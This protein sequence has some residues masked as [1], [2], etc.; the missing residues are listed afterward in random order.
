MEA[1]LGF[2]VG[3]FLGTKAGREGLQELRESW[4]VVSASDEF[5]GLTT[6][7]KSMAGM[8]MQQSVKVSMDV[9]KGNSGGVVS[10]VTDRL[11]TVLTGGSN[12]RRAA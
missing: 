12:G 10:L 7:A 3:Y 4:K 2:A 11:Q 5:Q 8:A 6:T 1:L 9:A